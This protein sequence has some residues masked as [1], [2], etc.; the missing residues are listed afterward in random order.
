MTI[1]RNVVLICMVLLAFVLHSQ[2]ITFGQQVES[3]VEDATQTES[4]NSGR[5]CLIILGLPGDPIHKTDFRRLGNSIYTQLKRRGFSK[6]HVIILTHEPPQDSQRI[7]SA[8]KESMEKVIGDLGQRLSSEDTLWVIFI[9][10]ADHDGEHARF[11]I[12]GPDLRAIDYADLFE[13]F[14]CK[15]QV[16]WLTMSSSG[17]FTEPLSKENRIIVTATSRDP[18]PN[19]TEFPALFAKSLAS[20][21]SEL[22]RDNDRKVSV[23]ELFA[24]TNELVEAAYAAD[25]RAATEHATIDDNADGKGTEWE[26]ILKEQQRIAQLGDDPQ[27]KRTAVRIDGDLAGKVFVPALV[28]REVDGVEANSQPAKDPVAAETEDFEIE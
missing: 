5:H 4:D 17:W 12:P 22:D 25:T 15:E 7:F 1:G 20:P 21:T 23:L 27:A 3:A 11:H 16:F 28:K 6:E 9:G 26:E 24:R 10:H 14:R 8:K 2:S 13:N 19:E 18:E